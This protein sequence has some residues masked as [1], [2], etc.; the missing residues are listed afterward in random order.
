MRRSALPLPRYVLRKPIKSGWGYFF[1]V[2]TWARKAGCPVGNEAL[3]T[4]Y[5]AAVQRA[6]S[7]LLAAFDEWRR[8]TQPRQGP[9]RQPI[10]ADGPRRLGPRDA[11]GDLCRAA[12]IPRQ[13]DRDGVTVARHRG[14]DRVGMAAT[15]A[16][17]LRH[18]R[19]DALP[20]QG[21]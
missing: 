2:P 6:E 1:N 8:E 13:G 10:L 5:A 7:V 21:A 18:L 4:D 11:D 3:G 9:A 16:R 14:A 12:S 20:A 17:H 15:R 19:R